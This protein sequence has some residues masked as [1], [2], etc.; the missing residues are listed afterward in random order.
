[1][2]GKIIKRSGASGITAAGIPNVRKNPS[3]S[4][5]AKPSRGPHRSR[6][7]RHS[8]QQEAKTNRAPAMRSVTPMRASHNR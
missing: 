3:K 7:K 2:W 8:I 5:A 4:A 6:A 1:M